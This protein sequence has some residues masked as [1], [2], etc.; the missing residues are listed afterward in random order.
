MLDAISS[1]RNDHVGIF[2]SHIIQRLECLLMHSIC[3]KLYTRIAI[4]K[5]ATN[6]GAKDKLLV[7]GYASLSLTTRET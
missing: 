3:G 1:L 6:I 7:A 5:L 2:E 4:L